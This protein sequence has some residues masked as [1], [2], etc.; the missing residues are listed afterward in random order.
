MNQIAQ[1]MW[2]QEQQQ[3]QNQNN[4]NT[5]TGDGTGEGDSTS[6]NGNTGGNQGS[7]VTG[8]YI[9]PTPSCTIVTSTYG[10]RMHPIFGT[11]RFHSGIDIG[12]A[13]G[14]SVLAADGGTVTVATYSSSYG[15]YVMI[16]HSNGT[17]TLYAHMSS[18]AVSAGDTVTQGQTIGYVG[19][20]GWATGPHLHFEIRNASGGTENPLNYF[21]GITI[22]E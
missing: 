4:G 18:L 13:S 22:M 1:E 8:T 11:E 19:A 10:N 5:N 20:T 7:T 15:N 9:W 12:A 14:A 2:E 21:S 17:Y 6:D 3:N 16:Y